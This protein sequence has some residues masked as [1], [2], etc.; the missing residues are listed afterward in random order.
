MR[1][2]LQRVTRASVTVNDKVISSIDQGLCVLVGI[3][4]KDTEE[5]MDYIIKK[6]S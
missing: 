1:A 3:N 6:N 4:A 2:V 5:D